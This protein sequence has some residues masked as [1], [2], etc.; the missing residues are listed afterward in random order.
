LQETPQDR[1]RGTPPSAAP[2]SAGALRVIATLGTLQ[3]LAWGST[4]YLLAV[5]AP[6]IVRDTGWPYQWVMAGVSIGL[7]VAG[8]VSPRVGHAI[9]AHGGRPVLAAGAAVLAIGEVVIGSAQ[10]FCLL[11][12]RLDGARRGN[13]GRAL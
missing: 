1:T 9:N 8:V 4:F 5:L 6:S 3:I 2:G 10:N 11:S 13:G 7:F 12:C